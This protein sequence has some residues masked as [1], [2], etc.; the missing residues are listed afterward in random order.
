[1]S[2]HGTVVERPWSPVGVRVSRRGGSMLRAGGE[3]GLVAPGSFMSGLKGGVVMLLSE[4]G[5]K[6]AAAV[7]RSK[8]CES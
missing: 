2:E 5:A 7:L 8:S 3:V 4:W 6:R 1:M